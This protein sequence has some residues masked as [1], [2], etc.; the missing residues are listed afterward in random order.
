MK[1]FIQKSFIDLHECDII[2]QYV[3]LL[4]RNNRLSKV[5]KKNGTAKTRYVAV[6]IDDVAECKKKN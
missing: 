1:P 5:I 6:Y 2:S 3:E 4:D